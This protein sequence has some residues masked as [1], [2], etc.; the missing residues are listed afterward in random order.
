[1]GGN[2][3]RFETDQQAPDLSAMLA[4]LAREMRV[5]CVDRWTV[6][7]SAAAKLIGADVSVADIDLLVS[8]HDADA[9]IARWATH[10]QVVEPRDSDGLFRSHFARFNFFAWTVEVMGDMELHGEGGW[11]TVRV[12]DIIDMDLGD[13]SVPVPSLAEQ[14]R[15]FESFGR[16]K[17]LRRAAILRALP[18]G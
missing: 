5:C 17:D 12:A 11:Q 18:R 6:I 9:L 10:R 13:I 15:L 1:M 3:P 4:R 14:I 2:S 8:R 7:G 16:A